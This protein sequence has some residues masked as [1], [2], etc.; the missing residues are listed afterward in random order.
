MNKIRFSELDENFKRSYLKGLDI[1]LSLASL[2]LE[3]L[4]F[5]GDVDNFPR[6]KMNWQDLALEYAKDNIDCKKNCEYF[7]KFDLLHATEDIGK[8]ISNGSLDGFRKKPIEV[9]GSDVKRS[10]PH[11]IRE[12]VLNAYADYLYRYNDLELNRDNLDEDEYNKKFFENEAALHIRL[13]HI[14]PFEDYNGR[15]MRTI[16]TV[17]LLQNNHA[18]AI[19]TEKTKREYCDYIE[20]GDIKGLGKFLRIES[21]KEYIRMCHLYKEYEDS[22]MKRTKT[23][24]K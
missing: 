5:D 6:F 18:P 12:D 14:H 23:L 1:S 11:M 20:N 13:L 8:I 22:N 16:L 2:E 9:I 17:N 4:N 21:L 15:T 3:G 19:V 24:I 10:E 7:Y